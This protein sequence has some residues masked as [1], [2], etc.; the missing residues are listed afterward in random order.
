MGLDDVALEADVE[1]PFRLRLRIGDATPVDPPRRIAE[2]ATELRDRGAA[3]AARADRVA[4]VVERLGAR[5]WRLIGDEVADGAR[6][7]VG[8]SGFTVLGGAPL[9]PAITVARDARPAQ[10][11]GDLRD[12]LGGPGTEEP[13]D[14]ATVQ[15]GG[16]DLPIRL[17]GET[18]ALVYSLR[19]YL[20]TFSA[21]G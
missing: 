12:A 20:E 13:A 6:E 18:V 3:V 5:G 19:T 15:L 7:T 11:A 4:T 8:G 14:Q 16:Y 17:E 21:R 9:P 10:I 1:L 2:A